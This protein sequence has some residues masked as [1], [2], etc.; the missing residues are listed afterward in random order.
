MRVGIVG[1]GASG[2]ICAYFLIQKGIDVTL[3]DKK[4]PLLTLLP[5]G[6][7]RCNLAHAE[8]DFKELTQNYPRG[9]KFLYSIF[10]KFAT[11]ETISLFN[12]LGI[13]TYTQDDNRIFPTSNSSKLVR[14]TI[15]RNIKD[16]EIIKEYVNSICKSETSF[17]VQTNHAEY[18]FDKVIL[19]T[20]GH[21]GYEIAEELG[22]KINE[23]K[24]SLVGLK[25]QND[26]KDISGVVAKNCLI[27][28]YSGDI[29]FTHFG[30]SGPLIFQISSI[31][32]YKKYPY[33][34][35]IDLFPEDIDFQM[36]LNNNSHKDI[37]NILGEILP[38]RLGSKIL[39]ELDI[40]QNTKAHKIDGKMRDMIL[41]RIHN[42][43]ITIIGADKGEETV[44]AG[45]IA[46]DQL[47]PKTLEVKNIPN[48]YCIGEV[49]DIDGFC[50]GFNLQN[51]WSTAYVCAEGICKN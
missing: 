21:S 41:N 40:P 18:F 2:C 10:S 46:L 44:T 16:A 32:A 20:G 43:R 39:D 37:K 29:L 47:N 19:A 38:Q 6:G 3:F 27:N 14:E 49:L 9:E 24:P 28:H 31:N 8:Y 4:S 23:T 7:G 12:D 45:G 35:N 5:T 25:T 11:K 1:A 15:L 34:L 42:Y 13:T 48:L 50:G 51:A 26:F 36:V 22:L 17:K 30:I 33:E